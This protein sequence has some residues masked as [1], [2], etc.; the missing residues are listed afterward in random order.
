VRYFYAW[1]PLFVIGT[2]SILSLPWLGLIALMVAALIPLAALA[3][4]AWAVISWS[5]MLV[6]ATSRAWHGRSGATPRTA[7]TL[8][9]ARR[10]ATF[11][12]E[13]AS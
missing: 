5:S 3:G 2:I 13:A 11:R 7:V 9:P 1:T 4:L 12:E 8:S 6:R 10:Q